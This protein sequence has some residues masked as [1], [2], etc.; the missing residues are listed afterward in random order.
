MRSYQG[1]CTA[2]AAAFV[3]ASAHAGAWTQEKGHGQVILTGSYYQ[4]DSLWNNAGT[5]TA[6]PEYRNYVLNPYLEYG[7][8]DRFTVGANLLLVQAE[9]DTNPNVDN[10]GLADTELFLRGKLY[11]HAGFVVSAEPMVKIP[12]NESSRDLPVIGS[13]HPDAG[14]GLSAGYGFTAFG[15]NHFANVDAGYRYRFSDP[16]DQMKFAATVGVGVTAQW[17]IMPQA[18]ATYRMDS[19]T[20]A[21]FTQS[22]G[23]DYN[24]VK[25]QLSAVY[26][27]RDDLSLQAGAFSHVDGK[28]TGGGEG[29]LLAVWKSF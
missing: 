28:N 4:T 23:D 10:W 5:E 26:K 25:L 11:E 29:L 27:M 18:F 2:V 13:R 1:L 20:V 24:L 17:M 15:Q 8:T 6:Q 7:L 22:S 3:A 21:A 16:K 19:P 12:S 14:L 9:Q